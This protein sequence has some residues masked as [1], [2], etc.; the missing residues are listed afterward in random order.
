[1]A[2]WT[3]NR[4]KNIIGLVLAPVVAYGLLRWFEHHQVFHPSGRFAAEG[5]S[6][7]VAF[8]EV[9]LTSTD[10]T[11]LNAWFFPT[12]PEEPAVLICHGNGGNISHRRE[13][14]AALLDLN[15]NVLAFD[16]RGYGRSEGRP[17]EAGI[18]ADAEAAYA[19]LRKRGFAADNI[20]ALGDSL[21]GGVATELATR[22]PLGGLILQSTFT[23]IPDIGAEFF[24][25]LPVRTLATIHLDNYAKLPR[26]NLPILVMHSRADTLIPFAHGER[27]FNAANPPRLFSELQGDHNDTL[28][29]GRQEFTGAIRDF[30]NLRTLP[31]SEWPAS[32]PPNTPR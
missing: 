30:L 31:A 15:L 24:P 12:S 14:Y 16:Y 18:C 32:P 25:W 1:M 3:R 26:L 4:L 8:E 29:A 6:L 13:L 22:H 19:W 23:S 28:Q 27:L 7:G 10:G 17:S 2:G 5:D 9:W 20:L 21:G 11:R